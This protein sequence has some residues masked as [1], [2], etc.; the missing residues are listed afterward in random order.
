M[1]MTSLNPAQRYLLS[2]DF[3]P[4][5]PVL[6][7]LMGLCLALCVLLA[8][9]PLSGIGKIAAGLIHTCAVTSAGGVKCWGGSGYGQLGDNST[10]DRPTAVDVTG[11]AS[12]VAA[13]ATGGYHSCALM[14]A[15]GVKCWGF[16]DRGQLGDNSTTDRLTAVDVSGLPSGA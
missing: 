1:N 9:L 2:H 8:S 7:W 10:M 5:R 16:N 15:G 13:I 3:L 12:G 11:L 14:S 4:T 6:A